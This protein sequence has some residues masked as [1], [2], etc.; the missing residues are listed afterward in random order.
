MQHSKVSSERVVRYPWLEGTMSWP[1]QHPV[2]AVLC[3]CV[4]QQRPPPCLELVGSS[5]RL[6][7]S[8]FLISRIQNSLLPGPSGPGVTVIGWTRRGDVPCQQ[9]QIWG[10]AFRAEVLCS[11]C[12]VQAQPP[13]SHLLLA[14][15]RSGMAPTL[16]QASAAQDWHRTLLLLP[17][18]PAPWDL[19]PRH[20]RRGIP[21][22]LTFLSQLLFCCY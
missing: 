9:L 5:V 15:T 7:G 18:C 8:T 6:T 11:C 22:A 13:F 3:F 10:R 4:G 1:F 20:G 2:E 19:L 21:K 12:V 16:G 14:S 17:V